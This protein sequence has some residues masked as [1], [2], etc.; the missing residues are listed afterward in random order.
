MVVPG[1][2]RLKPAGISLCF[3]PIQAFSLLLFKNEFDFFTG[4][5][6]C[7]EVFR[8]DQSSECFFLRLINHFNHVSIACKLCDHGLRQEAFV[9]IQNVQGD[10]MVSCIGIS[11]SHAENE[12][13]NQGENKNPGKK[14]KV[15]KDL[16][17]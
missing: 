8:E 9:L 17:R 7:R 6:I 16:E 5:H 11:E 1:T 14:H 10:L 3:P 2:E 13:E 12:D 4:K 15:S